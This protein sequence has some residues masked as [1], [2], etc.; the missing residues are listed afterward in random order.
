MAYTPLTMSQYSA[1]KVYFNGCFEYN[2]QEINNQVKLE[3]KLE[4]FVAY[5]ADIGVI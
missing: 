2:C 5:D 3:I 4:T 1:E